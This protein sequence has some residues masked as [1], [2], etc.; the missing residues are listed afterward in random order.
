MAK[1]LPKLCYLCGHALC[2]PVDND[3]VPM[4]QLWAP[5]LRKKHALHLVTIPVHKACNGAYQRDEDYFVRTILPFVPGSYAGD[6]LF[7]K[8]MADYRDEDRKRPLMQ[9]VLSEFER[10][11]SGLTLPTGKIAKRFEG[12]RVARIAWKIVRGLHF[13]HSGQVLPEDWTTSV[14]LHLAD[15]L[16][17]PPDH[18]LSFM[19][20]PNNPA[21]GA[22]PG[23]FTYRFQK[24][25]DAGDLHYWALLILDRILLIVT[26]HD[27][28]CSCVACTKR[29]DD[30]KQQ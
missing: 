16:T 15:N 5:E 9:K 29:L 7:R 27:F 6:A 3:H 13:H 24:F 1:P 4:Q 28:D 17:L 30:W 22:Y 12:E 23:V 21:H 25:P 11:P 19:S 20:M 26:F 10:K 2:Q 18:F 14:Q 8:A